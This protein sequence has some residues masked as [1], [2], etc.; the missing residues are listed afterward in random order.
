[1]VKPIACDRLCQSQCDGCHDLDNCVAGD[2]Q[3]GDLLLCMNCRLNYPDYIDCPCSIC[4]EDYADRISSQSDPNTDT[5]RL[6]VFSS[7][8]PMYMG[9][10]E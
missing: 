4:D 7:V 1:M 8:D 10:Y 6:Q 2:Y 3:Y 5:N 9:M